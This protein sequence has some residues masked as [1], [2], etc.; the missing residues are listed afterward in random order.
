M[1][2]FA[3]ALALLGG[4]SYATVSGPSRGA[5]RC[6]RSSPAPTADILLGGALLLLGGGI[7]IAS[8]AGDDD[9]GGMSIRPLFTV[10]G[11]V[12]LVVSIPFLASGAT[13]ISRIS[14]CRAAQRR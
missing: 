11:V 12:P 14:A 3:L 2:A 1:R 8:A 7:L 10:A 13:G 4:C 6:T 5:E 9:G